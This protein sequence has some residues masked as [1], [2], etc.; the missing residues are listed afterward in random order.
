M[1]K[2]LMATVTSGLEGSDFLKSGN[3]VHAP[4]LS[5]A[6][7]ER[8]VDCAIQHGADALITPRRPDDSALRL[9]S[10]SVP[11]PKF[12]SYVIGVP[13]ATRLPGITEFQQNDT[14]LDALATALRRCEQQF[15]L[16]RPSVG[17]D[18][19]NREVVLIGAGIVNLVTALEL[20]DNGYHVTVLDKSPSPG[21]KDWRQYGCT[22]AGDDARMFTFTEMDSY[23]NQDFHGSAPSWF[24]V[25]VT[26]NG[27]LAKSGSALPS[28]ERAWIEEFQRV[29]A[30]LARAYNEDI[31]AFTAEAFHGWTRLRGDHPGLFED[32]V[33]AEDILR[34][35]SDPR[36]LE[37]AL[38]RHR[39]IGAV[40]RELTPAEVARDFPGLARPVQDGELAGGLLVP[41][42]TV[43]VHK[44]AG[45]IIA[46]LEA[47]GAVFHWDTPVR[48]VRRDDA[49]RLTG[50]ACDRPVPETAHV[51][52]SPGFE[53]RELLAGSPCEGRIHGVLGGWIRISNKGI[54]LT[55]SLKVARKGHVTEDANVTVAVD[56][57]GQEILIVGSG[58][59]YVGTTTD[60]IDERQLAAMR[61]G[62]RDTIERLFPDRAE[63]PESSDPAE[64]YA[65]K[66]CVRPWTATS[67][68]LYHA[69]TTVNERLFIINGGH[70]TGGFAQA[71]A[72]GRA[73]LASLRGEPH[74]M[75]AL[76]HPERFTA[77][78]EGGNH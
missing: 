30:W 42:F 50:F 20:T 63:L 31:F 59:G 3:I 72:I 65:F 25:P 61:E 6:S 8:V 55:H 27:W 10:E 68:G 4:E 73:V 48:G 37:A 44:F 24:R 33:F 57:D 5:L 46:Q 56:S 17:G 36:G 12:L 2:V 1:T 69:E 35:Y 22:H 66:F 51:V 32:A 9:W 39:R 49:G 29:P 74:P 23:N 70:N 64:N 71:P 75:H 14:D 60:G 34:L 76:Y 21:S 47:R 11:G 19:Q 26:E 45:K 18:P 54:D 41:G 67:L 38:A 15:A 13:G 43:N 52:A 28:S 7:D 40:L 53:G 16:G 77:F 58:Y 62:I 78:I